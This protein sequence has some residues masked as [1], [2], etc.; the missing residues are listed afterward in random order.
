MDGQTGIRGYGFAGLQL[1]VRPTRDAYMYTKTSLMYHSPDANATAADRLHKP[2][3]ATIM[4]HSDNGTANLH[5]SPHVAQIVRMPYY[6]SLT[7]DMQATKD[8]MAR[9]G[10]CI[11]NSTS[12]QGIDTAQ[13]PIAGSAILRCL[14]YCASKISDNPKQKSLDPHYQGR[15]QRQVP[16]LQGVCAG[17]GK[18]IF[19]IWRM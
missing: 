3:C 12:G 7:T 2:D 13:V 19:D 14:G 17:G 6:C 9:T 15:L 1:D 5:S 4:N 11:R 8:S 10:R 18:T 16:M